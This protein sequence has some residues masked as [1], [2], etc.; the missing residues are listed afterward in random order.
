MTAAIQTAQLSSISGIGDDARAL[1]RDEMA[2]R[3]FTQL[4]IDGGH[5]PDAVRLLAH[6]LP[7]RESVWWAWVSARRAAGV[8]PAAPIQASL[9]A[10][11]KWIAQ[12]TEEN[13]R[14]AMQ[15]AER[16]GLHTAAGCAGLAAFFCGA[17]IA[18]AQAPP[19]APGPYDSAKAV[20]GAILLSAVAV[21]EKIEEQFRAFLQ[22]GLGVAARI[23]LW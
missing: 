4:L 13:R 9:A 7:K 3:E 14:A 1:L 16:A 8:E 20:A 12:P 22:Q 17:T 10:T 15:A 11:E 21:P 5:F 6:A 19:V 23:K 18:P 2:P